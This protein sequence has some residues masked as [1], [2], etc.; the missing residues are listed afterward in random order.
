MYRHVF[1][2]ICFLF[3]C[4]T[5]LSLIVDDMSNAA[6][7]NEERRISDMC[8]F[9]DPWTVFLYLYNRPD[10]ARVMMACYERDHEHDLVCDDDPDAVFG[11]GMEQFD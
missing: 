9:I 4:R 3:H 5:L 1:S 7:R 2:H 8:G 6:P 11:P 10:R